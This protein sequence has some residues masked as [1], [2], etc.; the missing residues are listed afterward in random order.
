[1]CVLPLKMYGHFEIFRGVLAA[2]F[3]EEITIL[4]EKEN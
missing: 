4:A 3:E 1:M 2:L